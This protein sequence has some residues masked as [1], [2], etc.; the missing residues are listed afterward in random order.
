MTQ[1]VDMDAVRKLSYAE[2]IALIE[3]IV[4]TIIEDDVDCSVSEEV[5]AEMERR[6]AELDKDPSIAIPH[7]EMMERLRKLM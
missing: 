3:Q 2:R 6:A 1:V 7:D 4:A 5:F